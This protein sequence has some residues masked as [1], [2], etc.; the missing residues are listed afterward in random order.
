LGAEEKRAFA[1]EPE[2]PQGGKRAKKP[3]EFEAMFSGT[4]L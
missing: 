1:E 4:S 3:H 2:A